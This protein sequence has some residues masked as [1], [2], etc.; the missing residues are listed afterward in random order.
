MHTDD[1]GV[2]IKDGLMLLPR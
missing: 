1:G 2:Q